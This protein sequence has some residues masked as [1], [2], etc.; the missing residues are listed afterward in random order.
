MK[1]N[2]KK[3]ISNIKLIVVMVIFGLLY[4]LLVFLLNRNNQY[5]SGYII[6]SNI[7]SFYCSALSCTAKENT[8][9]AEKSFTMAIYQK[10]KFKD[11]YDSIYSDDSEKW[12]FYQNSVWQKVNG[13]F[14]GIDQN[15]EYSYLDVTTEKLNTS[16][17]D[18][19]TKVIQKNNIQNYHS[20]YDENVYLVDLN[21]DGNQE[22]II[23]TSNQMIDETST[24]YFSI[25]LIYM[26]NAWQE[27]YVN[28]NI[29]GSDYSLPYY[30]FN[31]AI[32]VNNQVHILI[33]KGYYSDVGT[34]SS[35]MLK[36]NHNKV[37]EE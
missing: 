14:I 7:D 1:N 23:A 3:E 30:T 20:L 4:M 37:E 22:R 15:L 29:S 12:T 26:N 24:D 35:I 2:N 8:E 19:I 21:D 28:T 33:T 16:D 9:I 34:S 5:S 18:E 10:G 31:A 11:N 27:I 17:I 25:L 36:V 13:D 32:K 6:N